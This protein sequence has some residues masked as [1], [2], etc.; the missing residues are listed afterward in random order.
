LRLARRELARL[1][2]D[3]QRLNRLKSLFLSMAAHDLRTPLTSIR[4]YSTLLAKD[5]HLPD[6]YRKPL[7]TIAVQA[8]K[9]NRLISDLLDLDQIEQ[10]RL[11]IKPES[12]DLGEIV[13]EVVEAIEAYARDQGKEIATVLPERPLQ[14]RADSAAIWRVL[15]NLVGNAVKYTDRGGRIRVSASQTAAETIIQ[16]ADNG[17][18][19]SDEEMSRLFQLYYRTGQAVDSKVAGTGVGL[20]IVKT[21][22]EAHGG[23]IAVSSRPDQ[24]STF[25]VRLPTGA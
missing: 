7:R 4:G 3:L 6:Q 5:A 16:V 13:R 1:N 19:M 2:E 11:A 10:G 25:T 8:D 20:F 12:C 23:S 9:L 21:L 18:G 14:I 15:H 24:G 22:V 17:L